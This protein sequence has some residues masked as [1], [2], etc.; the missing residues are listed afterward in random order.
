M[1]HTNF[2]GRFLGFCLVSFV[3]LACTEEALNVSNGGLPPPKIDTTYVVDSLTGDTIMKIDTANSVIDTIRLVDSNGDTIVLTDT[4]YIPTDTTI[5]WVGKS[6][7]LITEVTTTNLDWLDEDGNDPGWVEIYNAGDQPASL[8]GYSLVENT[9]RAR[10]WVFGDVVIPAKSFKNIFCDNKDLN[11]A[12]E[13][14][15]KGQ[16][17]YRPHTNW[18]LERN[19]GSIYL[20]DSYYGIRDSVKYPFLEPGVSWGRVDGGGWMYF[21]KPTP[22]K[23]NNE[24]TSYKGMGPTL[25]MKN[26][27][28]GFYNG[29]VTVN[30]PEVAAGIKVRCTEDGSIPNENSPEF[31][32]PKTFESNTTLR[33]AAFKD[34]YLTKAVTT[35]TYFIEENVHMPVVAVSVDP[36]FFEKYYKKTNGGEP[37]MDHD[38]MY[39]PNESYPNDSGELPVHV[40]YFEKGSSSGKSTWEI[41]AGISL[42]GGWSRMERKKSVAIVMREE[43]QDGWLKYPLFET[44]KGV[45]DK[46]KG[47]NL[48]NNGNRFVADYFADAVGGAIL[49]G[50]DVDYQRSRQVVVYYNGKYYGIHD[51]RERYNKNFVETNYGIDASTVNFIKHLN[52]EITAS[53]G[54]I[55]DYKAMLDFINGND[56]TDAAN[57]EQAKALIDIG[58]FADYMA[59]EIYIHNGD[60]PDNNVRAWKSP[61]RPWK[62]MIYDLDHGFVWDW[63]VAGFSQ[64]MNMFSWIKKGGKNSCNSAIC[65][66]MLYNN[67]IKNDDFKR[68]FINRSSVML[69]TYLNGKNVR[70]KAEFLA[71]MLDQA[72]VD[73]DMDVEAYKQRR[74]EYAHGFDPYGEKLA[75][76]AEERDG[77]VKSEYISEFGLSDQIT[78]GFKS[79][80]GVVLMEG[81]NLP[82]STAT[83]TSYSGKFFSGIP[84][85]ISA[86]PAAGAVFAGWSDGVADNPRLVTPSD[87]VT[88][89]AV[90]K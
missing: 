11:V 20:I 73:C 47:F 24:A 49:E 59:A 72:D 37:D 82:G 5:H 85:E 28:G 13:G 18:K 1:R 62:F 57:Y 86:I 40:E 52:K 38:Q 68:L 74:S 21:G 14:S 15:D 88:Y 58:N 79:D 27:S 7:L 4:V 12:L 2:F 90:F 10:K 43:Y 32:S 77:V 34:G 39:A 66:P 61:G 29:P 48:R 64:S 45:N 35:N 69:A 71:S 3:L 81:M 44:R 9:S 53:N 22:E 23:P 51:M 56:M 84:M 50:S 63:T 8:K 42:M 26:T 17:H 46:Y 36:S 80:N 70:K 87:G 16:N 6:S 75:P 65:F 30:P 76:W 19:G 78:V 31:N 67:L 41:D 33:C 89:T 83:S 54:T 55:D 25:D 60:W